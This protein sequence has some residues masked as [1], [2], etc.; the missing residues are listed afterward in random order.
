MAS[1]EIRKDSTEQQTNSIGQRSETTVTNLCQWIRNIRDLVKINE[2]VEK[3]N[4][5]HLIC[6]RKLFEYITQVVEPPSYRYR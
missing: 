6:I 2:K 5:R 4:A 3:D 1:T